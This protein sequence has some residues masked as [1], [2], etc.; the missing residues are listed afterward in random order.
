MKLN[1]VGLIVLCSAIAGFAI[2]GLLVIRD[3]HP[4]G[5][6]KERLKMSYDDGFKA[7][8]RAALKEAAAY[9]PGS[10]DR[11]I[12]DCVSK[13]ATPEVMLDRK[14]NRRFQCLKIN[15]VRLDN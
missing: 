9:P 5:W 7:G 3:S 13:G 10:C 12:R 11:Q 1:D 14:L 2:Y 8:R 4:S 6:Y 15:S